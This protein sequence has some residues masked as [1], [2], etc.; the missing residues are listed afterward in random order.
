[1]KLTNQEQARIE[2][3]ALFVLYGMKGNLI[4]LNKVVNTVYIDAYISQA[5]T[6]IRL[7]QF[8]RNPKLITKNQRQEH[9]K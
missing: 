6:D 7:K 1:M 8:E 3:Y 2:N 5:I 9:L 4:H